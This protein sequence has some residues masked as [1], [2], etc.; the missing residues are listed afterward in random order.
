[1]RFTS[2]TLTII[3]VMTPFWI[4]KAWGDHVDNAT[5]ED[6]P[7]AIRET[8][9]IDDEHGAFWVGHSDSDNVLEVHKDLKIFYNFND[10][11]DDQ[12]QAQFSTWDEIMNL[13]TLFL[14][15]E[16]EQTAAILTRR[17]DSKKSD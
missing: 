14:D 6:I 15:S 2:Q 3:F 4:E 16:F 13:Y 8:V 7:I 12:L 11:P 10:N 9:S 17:H 5:M 1:M